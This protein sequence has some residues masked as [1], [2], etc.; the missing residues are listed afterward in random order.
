MLLHLP[1]VR[2]HMVAAALAF[3]LHQVP[4]KQLEVAGL[5]LSG[6]EVLKTLPTIRFIQ[7]D[8]GNGGA[9][10]SVTRAMAQRHTCSPPSGSPALSA[11]PVR[12][13]GDDRA[14]N[15]LL[16]RRIPHE[17]ERPSETG[18]D[19]CFAFRGALHHFD[20]LGPGGLALHASHVSG[21]RD[22]PRSDAR[23]LEHYC[24]ERDQCFH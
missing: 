14:G 17:E 7:F 22:K 5:D 1:R 13:D 19:P 24:P 3:L 15:R 2:A 21:P 11:A 10:H 9:M 18:A 6:S 23:P 20:C 8:L 16:Q 12:A 4:A